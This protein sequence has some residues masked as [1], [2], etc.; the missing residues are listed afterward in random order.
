MGKDEKFFD[1]TIELFKAYQSKM[2]KEKPKGYNVY[3]AREVCKR[4]KQ[5]SFLYEKIRLYES[6]VMKSAP[7]AFGLSSN[8]ITADDINTIVSTRRVP[9]SEDFRPYQALLFEMEVFVE[10]FYFFAWRTYY[11]IRN[12]SCPLP[13]LNRFK[14]EGI[15]NVR[16]HLIEHPE[17][18]S[19]ILTQSFMCG[20]DEGP[21]L[22][23][24]RPDGDTF[25]IQDQGLWA[26][27]EEFKT[28]LEKLLREALEG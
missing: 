4:L 28:N 20:G 5:L 6:R 13:H 9:L 22:K 21:V 15:L 27:A 17:K 19:Q 11:I 18:Q 14:A 3:L 7:K 26:N 16:N 1:S 10:A 2:D 24:A 12:K 8:N 23:N 25:E